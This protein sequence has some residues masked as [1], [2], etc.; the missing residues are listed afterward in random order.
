VIDLTRPPGRPLVVGHR[1]APAVA[2][3][4][5]LEG[6]RAAAALGVDLVE[7]DVLPLRDGRIVV[8]HS[9]EELAPALPTLEE[10]LAWFAEEA[11][12]L[13]LHVD[14]KGGARVEAAVQELVRYDVDGRAVLSSAIPGVLHAARGVSSRVRLGLTYPD[15][16][17]G[18][19]RRR[20]ARPLVEAGLEALR[21]A[22]PR[23]LPRLVRRQ[24]VDALMLQHRVVTR[25]AVARA[26]ALGVSVLTWTVDDPR[27]VKR[28]VEA[29]VDGVITN[30]PG[31]L[32]ATLAP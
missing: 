23:R 26:H 13:G 30:D 6:F 10:T 11:P 17:L 1:G 15:D 7:F 31:N 29:G 22:L 28:V 18:I 27:D 14:F 3:E 21:A 4:N 2:P 9:A 19:A 8:A 16:R 12:D 24:P 25:E 5:T 20:F 32:L